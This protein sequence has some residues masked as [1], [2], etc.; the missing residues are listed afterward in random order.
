MFERLIEFH[1]NAKDFG[2]LELAMERGSKRLFL[3]LI[4]IGW[5]DMT[6]QVCVK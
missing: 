6:P 3:K 4:E 1:E 5:D 2:L